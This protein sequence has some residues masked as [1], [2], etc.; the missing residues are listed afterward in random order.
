[1]LM[2][3]LETCPRQP[4]DRIVFSGPAPGIRLCDCDFAAGG[5]LCPRQAGGKGGLKRSSAGRG[6]LTLALAAGRSIA[7]G[8]GGD[9]AR[10]LR[11]AA[12]KSRLLLRAVFGACGR[13]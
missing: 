6:G 8:P 3:Y 10:H 13:D 4:G 11:G 12:D 7:L 2:E 5:P 1:M 9:A